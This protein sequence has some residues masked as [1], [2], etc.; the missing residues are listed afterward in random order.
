MV[1]SFLPVWLTCGEI[2]SFAQNIF[3]P[4]RRENLSKPHLLSWRDYMPHNYRRM[5]LQS[6]HDATQEDNGDFFFLSIFVRRNFSS[7]LLMLIFRFLPSLCSFFPPS[8]CF[9]GWLELAEP[10]LERQTPLFPLLFHRM[11]E[12]RERERE[13]LSNHSSEVMFFLPSR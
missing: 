12:A 7:C 9:Y 2:G 3:P 4:C 11:H 1:S 5:T 6:R 13:R 8:R 10:F